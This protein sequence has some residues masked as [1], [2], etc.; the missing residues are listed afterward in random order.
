MIAAAHWR[1]GGP[2]GREALAVPGEVPS[3]SM[4]YTP[5]QTYWGKITSKRPEPLTRS[6]IEMTAFR[7]GCSIDAARRAI[8]MG[9]VP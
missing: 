2:D 1:R 7:L 3:L 8:L 4:A 9:M 5:Q 6:H